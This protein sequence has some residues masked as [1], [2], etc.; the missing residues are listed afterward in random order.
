MQS[1]GPCDRNACADES[2]SE[3]AARMCIPSPKAGVKLLRLSSSG[4]PCPCL[5]IPQTLIFHRSHEIVGKAVRVGTSVKSI[6][7]GDIVGVGA[8]IAS[9]YHCK[10]CKNDNENYCPSM[11]DTYVRPPLDCLISRSMF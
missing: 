10:Q 5:A 6:K 11:I 8:Q 1:E 9:C 2:F 4:E 3:S 7:V